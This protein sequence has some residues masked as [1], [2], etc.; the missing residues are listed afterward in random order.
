MDVSIHKPSPYFDPAEL[1]AELSGIW[2]DAGGK[3]VEMR[4][5][6]LELLGKTDRKSVV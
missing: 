2:K 5:R 4:A 1:R 6:L 3:D